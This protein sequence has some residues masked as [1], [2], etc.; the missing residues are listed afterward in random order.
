MCEIV[1]NLKNNACNNHKKLFRI[2][3]DRS[4]KAPAGTWRSKT[5]Q[6]QRSEADMFTDSSLLWATGA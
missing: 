6:E 1:H 2:F 3:T 5:G 4:Q